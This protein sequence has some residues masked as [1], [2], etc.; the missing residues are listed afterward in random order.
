MKT[1]TQLAQNHKSHFFSVARRVALPAHNT[2][3]VVIKA[4]KP[5][6]SGSKK[7]YPVHSK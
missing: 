2:K 1:Q 3:G 4:Q 7:T 6:V 5:K